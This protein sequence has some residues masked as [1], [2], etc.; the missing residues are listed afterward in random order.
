M[1]AQHYARTKKYNGAESTCTHPGTARAQACLGRTA[2]GQLGA[3]ELRMPP[4][5][6]ALRC[7]AGGTAPYSVFGKWYS[8]SPSSLVSLSAVSVTRGQPQSEMIQLPKPP[9]SSARHRILDT[10]TADES[11]SPEADNRPSDV[12]SGQQQPNAASQCLRS[13]RH[14]HCTTS[15]HHKGGEPATTRHFE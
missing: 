15:R 5:H 8:N 3:S 11:G 6:T 13:P 9:A 1:T 7:K 2:L 4:G 14:I 12:K 10:V